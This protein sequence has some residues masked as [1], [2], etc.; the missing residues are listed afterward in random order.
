[1]LIHIVSH[2]PDM[3]MPQHDFGD[4]FHFRSRAGGAGGVVWEVEKQP[5]GFRGDGG[6][7][8]FGPQ[9]ETVI[10]G[11]NHRHRH[12]ARELDDIG[13][14]DPGRRGDDDFVAW[15]A[16]GHDGVEDDLL[17]AARHQNLAWIVVEIVITLELPLDG[18]AQGRRS[19]GG[20]IFRIAGNGGR[21][22]RFNRV[23]RG[24]E[25]RLAGRQADDLDAL[26]REVAG[27]LGHGKRG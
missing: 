20:R 2:D 1:M 22:R 27:F 13:I 8:I 9:A 18:G 21:V 24:R 17:A 11:A 16:G 19:V 4:L 26:S 14:A 5:F 12:G 15:V 6:F 10:F 25:I 3:R 7:E 23:G